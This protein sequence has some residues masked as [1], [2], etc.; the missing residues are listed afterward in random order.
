MGILLGFR[1]AFVGLQRDFPLI[2][3]DLRT[4]PCLVVF[5]ASYEILMDF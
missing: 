4:L 3:M 1:G 5:A 2:S